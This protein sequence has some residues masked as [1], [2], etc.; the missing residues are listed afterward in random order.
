ME[1]MFQNR[2]Q[3]HLSYSPHS[4]NH[5]QCDSRSTLS[6]V[7]KKLSNIQKWHKCQAERLIC[8]L[9]TIF[10]LYLLHPGIWEMSDLFT[11]QIVSLIHIPG[12]KE[13]K[14]DLLE[15]IILI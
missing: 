9:Y 13:L 10:S 12:M 6:L 14:P 4:G 11:F 8:V 7:I 15:L 3:A 5:T 2:F 1:H